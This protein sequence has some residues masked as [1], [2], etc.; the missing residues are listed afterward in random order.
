MPV[1]ASDIERLRNLSSMFR[2]L[3]ELPPLLEHIS[4][5]EQTVRSLTT[6]ADK[7]RADAAAAIAAKNAAAE[8]MARDAEI[9]R[10]AMLDREKAAEAVE[11]A[12]GEILVESTESA[13]KIVADAERRAKAIVDESTARATGMD[14]NIA[15][16]TKEVADLDRRIA[17][18][19]ET[20]RKQ[21]AAV[22]G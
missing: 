14:A 1:N 17:K 11:T 20:V 3:A 13:K 10:A 19:R 22:E 8:S 9:H 12:A 6:Q 7:L 18:A 5:A 4:G 2:A 21:L 15:A 16:K